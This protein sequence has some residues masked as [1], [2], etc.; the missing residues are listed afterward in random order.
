MPRLVQKVVSGGQSGV[1]RAALD[2][3]LALGIPCGGWCP[4]GR[5]TEDAPLPD[6]YPLNETP[7]ADYS[8]RTEWN[9]RDS[10]GTLVLAPGTPDGGSALTLELAMRLGRPSLAVDPRDLER[11]E[12]VREWLAR[13]RVGSLNV[14]GPRE[15]R[16][17]GAY[18][19]ARRFLGALLEKD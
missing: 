10:D 2:V 8:Q 6:R 12:E 15:S 5:R 11:V 4:R 19:A 14:A 18:D 7:S 1:D 13:Y 17:P 16:A 9:V 3:A